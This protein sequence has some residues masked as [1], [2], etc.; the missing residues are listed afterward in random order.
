[1]IEAHLEYKKPNLL[2]AHQLRT[3]SYKKGCEN[4][5]VHPCFM[6]AGKHNYLVHI[7]ETTYWTMHTTISEFRSE[8]P[9]KGKS[10]KEFNNH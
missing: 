10:F 7:P 6:K 5:Y 4:L 8:D 9:P 1:M 3:A 2:D